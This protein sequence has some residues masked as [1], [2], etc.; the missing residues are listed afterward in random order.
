MARLYLR[1]NES[2]FQLPQTQ[3]RQAIFRIPATQMKKGV[4]AVFDVLSSVDE[5]TQHV[6][7]NFTNFGGP[8]LQLRKPGIGGQPQKMFLVESASRSPL[9]I[10]RD[11]YYFQVFDQHEDVVGTLSIWKNGENATLLWGM[12]AMLSFSVASTT[13]LS[14]NVTLPNRDQVARSG[15][16]GSYWRMIVEAE[17]DANIA[18]ICTLALL[19]FPQLSTA[20]DKDQKI[21][22]PGICEKIDSE[23]LSLEL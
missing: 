9:Y 19:F 14:V 1:T 13:E 6:H 3:P 7:I 2:L 17:C 16:D 22:A 5:V 20:A 11:R 8:S 15:F 12:T 21:S 18:F 23:A 4:P 10:C